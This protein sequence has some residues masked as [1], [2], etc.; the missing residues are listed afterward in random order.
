MAL[1]G[2]AACAARPTEPHTLFDGRLQVDVPAGYVWQ[3]D[4]V[5]RM[6]SETPALPHSTGFVLHGGH[7]ALSR[8]FP[9]YPPGPE[10]LDRFAGED[11]QARLQVVLIPLVQS[12]EPD[13][14]IAQEKEWIVPRDATP[15]AIHDRFCESF[16]AQWAE[17]SFATFDPA[18]GIGRCVNFA[19]AFVAVFTRRVGDSL[20]LVDSLDFVEFL[21]VEKKGPGKAL[22][23]M[24][25]EEKWQVFRA[26]ANAD[27]AEQVLLSARLR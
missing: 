1:A 22:L 15:R 6:S 18:T 5:P 14:R 23:E 8:K 3:E 21:L 11:V 26:A 17:F 9:D 12:S 10:F 19:G 2:L 24:T 20:V 25:D 16:M 13:D 4:V 7:E 27:A